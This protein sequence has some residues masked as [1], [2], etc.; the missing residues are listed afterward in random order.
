MDKTNAMKKRNVMNTLFN[1]MGIVYIAAFM[2][3]LAIHF[4]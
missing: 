2:G 3:Y 1:V 4:I